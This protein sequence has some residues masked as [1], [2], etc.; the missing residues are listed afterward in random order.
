MELPLPGTDN[1]LDELMGPAEV[2]QTR[3]PLLDTQPA[4]PSPEELESCLLALVK[5]YEDDDRVAHE[6]ISSECRKYE[7][8]W[9]NIQD[10]IWDN[11]SRDWVSASGVLQTSRDLDVDPNV[12]DKTVGLYRS[13]GEIIASALSQTVPT[14][15]FFPSNADSG[16]DILTARTSTVISKLIQ[17]HNDAPLLFLK[18]LYTKFNQHFVAAYH[19]VVTDDAYGTVQRPVIDLKLQNTPTGALICPTC[20]YPEPM[21]DEQAYYDGMCPAC[22]GSNAPVEETIPEP[23][24]YVKEVLS[25]PKGRVRIEVFGPRHVKVQPYCKDV[26]S[27]PYLI[28]ETELHENLI[29][30]LYDKY[31]LSSSADESNL[32][33]MNRKPTN[34]AVDTRKIHTLKRCWL[35]PWAL[36]SIQDEEKRNALRLLAPQGLF[37]AIADDKILEM[38]AEDVDEHWTFC[39]DPFAEYIHGDPK[40]KFLVPIQD[41]YND[42]IMLALETILHNIP[43]M[44]ADPNVLNFKKYNEKESKPGQVNQAVAPDG[45][46][47]ASGF[48]QPQG[49]TLSKEVDNFTMRLQEMAQ[50]VIGAPPSI[51]GGAQQGGSATLGEYQQSRAQAQQRLGT[52][53]KM[54]NKWWKEIMEKAVQEFREFLKQL[55]AQVQDPNYAESFVTRTGENYVNVWIRLEDL[56]GEVGECEAETSD[57]F[58]VSWEQKRG[59]LFE[60]FQSPNPVLSNM[61]TDPENLGTIRDISGLYELK[62]PGAESRDKQLYEIEQL[63]V[64]Q[65]VQPEQFIDNHQVELTTIQTWANS[66]T[67]REIKLS[68]PQGYQMVLQHAMMHYAMMQ[69]M[70]APAPA[71]PGGGQP[72]E[73]PAQAQG[74]SRPPETNGAKGEPPRK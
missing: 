49:A 53:W 39:S 48:Y 37:M 46:T 28:M 64:G 63:L 32:Q 58:P 74:S 18:A 9:Q 35:R 7:L 26:R 13:Y 2:D 73:S 47:L 52:D 69:A 25:A 41:M 30:E 59:L 40:G 6:R 62:V 70:M 27:S 16:K 50:F 33:R 14:V 34:D 15:R 23:V 56:Q 67:G 43:E 24:P 31:T 19:T 54:L 65:P 60:I 68:N 12:L 57:Q 61:A 36:N 66:P 22:G 10:L 72:G 11:T 8:Y 71:P 29:K 20:G 3:E 4:V 51:W 42:D 21:M 44:F 5:E 17:R 1:S 45:Q 55:G 38:V